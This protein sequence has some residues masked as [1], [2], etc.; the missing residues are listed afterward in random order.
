MWEVWE[1]RKSRRNNF[2]FYNTDATGHDMTPGFWILIS[3][4]LTNL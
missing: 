4:D 3:F 2:S 1:D